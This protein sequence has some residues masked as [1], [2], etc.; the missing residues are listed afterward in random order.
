M[1]LPIIDGLGVNKKQKKSVNYSPGLMT[2]WYR[3]FLIVVVRNITLLS[4]I[5]SHN[6]NVLKS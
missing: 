3:L 6:V 1:L 4:L 5:G 2:S